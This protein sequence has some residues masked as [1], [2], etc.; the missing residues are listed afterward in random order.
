M[1]NSL[2]LYR[3]EEYLRRMKNC[4]KG[5]GV[6]LVTPFKADYSIDFD[7]L[8]KLVRLQLENGTDFLVVQGTT[9]ESPVLTDA[10]KQQV[11]ETVID[12]NAGRLNVV[13]GVGGNNTLEVGEKLKSI[14]AGVDGILSVSPYYNKPTQKGIVEHFKYLAAQT[15]LPIILYNVPGRT[16]S[17]MLP[18]T[19]LEL[20]QID[21]IVAV[22]E[23]SGNMEQ[24]MEIIQGA[25][26]GFE[27]LSG[28][29]ALTLPM[30]AT[31]AVGV[32][33]VVAQALPESFNKMVHLSLKGDFSVAKPL[34]LDLLNITK[35]FFEEGN[36]GG[37]KAALKYRGILENIVRMP[38]Q[39]ISGQLEERINKETA[40]IIGA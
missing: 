14:P 32:I 25:P 31:G 27:V 21:N 8:R 22:K 24:I 1:G 26:E 19:V 29:D 5:S 15:D 3:I 40:R 39:P 20:A 4:F 18:P 7:A 13:Y 37:V 16:G 28:D 2:H 11:L 30:I 38:L 33:S 17:N 9:G 35:M 10:E 34:H 12:E 36:P 23:A 6:A